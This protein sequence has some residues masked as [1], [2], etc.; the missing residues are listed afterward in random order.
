MTGFVKTNGK[1][2]SDEV[3]YANE[4][5]ISFVFCPRTTMLKPL[6]VQKRQSKYG[7]GSNYFLEEKH[8][9]YELHLN[10]GKPFLL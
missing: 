8:A 5:K 6:I 9:L 1:T 3:S 4:R 10:Y 2:S 7:I